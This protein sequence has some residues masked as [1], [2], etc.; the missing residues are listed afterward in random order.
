MDRSSNLG[1]MSASNLV[2]MISKVLGTETGT[3]SAFLLRSLCMK[4][5]EPQT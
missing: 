2:V 4:E 3:V 5:P 1:V